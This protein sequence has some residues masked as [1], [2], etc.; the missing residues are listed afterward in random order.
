MKCTILQEKI[1]T[2]LSK[3]VKN[4]C[5]VLAPPGQ[6]KTYGVLCAIS[7]MIRSTQCAPHNKVAVVGCSKLS[8]TYIAHRLKSMVDVSLVHTIS[9]HGDTN[10]QIA[11]SSVFI[12]CISL[13]VSWL[14]KKAMHASLFVIDDFEYFAYE[15][16]LPHMLSFMKH[17]PFCI[18]S[19]SYS[20]RSILNLSQLPARTYINSRQLHL[21]ITVQ[22]IMVETQWKIGILKDLCN[23]KP[24]RTLVFVNTADGV[25][26]LYPTL[27]NHHH[28]C[29]Q[30]K[31]GASTL[32]TILRA[33]K[34]IT[35]STDVMA[36]GIHIKFSRVICFDF[37]LNKHIM[38]KRL[39]RV[40]CEA[41]SHMA[42]MLVTRDNLI[43]LKLYAEDLNIN[44]EE[45]N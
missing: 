19:S 31:S 27:Q 12:A 13:M 39:G 35:I 24:H 45:Y 30:I 26:L 4:N 18:L 22:Y 34:G 43:S 44:I 20:R 23:T 2:N 16:M 17:T 38:L 29:T 1:C 42:V 10:S 11:N 37:P 33:N 32:E 41:A 5:V 40:D 14:Q 6:G 3:T 7:N 28:E 25:D 9:Q 21:N 8:C 36:N 15:P